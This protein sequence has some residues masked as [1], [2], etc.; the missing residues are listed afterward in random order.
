MVYVS[1][2]GRISKRVKHLCFGLCAGALFLGL[3]FLGESGAQLPPQALPPEIESSNSTDSPLILE[4]AFSTPPNIRG[5][6]TLEVTILSLVDA[7][8]TSVEINLPA[9]IELISGGISWQGD[10]AANQPVTL[11]LEVLTS[12]PGDWTIS[13]LASSQIS[14]GYTLVQAAHL[15]LSVQPEGV[16]IQESGPDRD[17]GAGPESEFTLLSSAPT[18]VEPLHEA[19]MVASKQESS[20]PLA[21][22]TAEGQI[23][24][25]G[26]VYYEDQSG[27]KRP[28]PYARVNIWDDDDFGDDLLAQTFT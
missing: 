14:A 1:L 19:P 18:G 22:T 23:V 11:A 9:G 15:T 10:L 25:F 8:N 24:V 12:Q 28:L 16:V 13:A 17:P 3:S 7:P 21:Q 20:E 4:L 27:V 26:Y 6:S 2:R 5:V